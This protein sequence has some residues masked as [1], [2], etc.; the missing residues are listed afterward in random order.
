MGLALANCGRDILF[1]ACSWGADGTP[2]WI[3]ST[4][5]HM[6]RS[7]GDISD[8]WESIKNISIKQAEIVQHAGN[9]CFNDMDMLVVGM[10]G[11]GHVGLTGCTFTEYRLHFSLWALLSS[12]LIIG[13][14]IRNMTDETRKILM[15]EKV[16]SI[17]QD[18]ASR[19][20]FMV[21]SNPNCPIWV[22]M[23]DNGDLAVGLFNFTDNDVRF[24]FSLTDIGIDRTTKMKLEFHNLWEDEVFESR[25]IV[26][27]VIPAHDCL[28][29]RAKVKNI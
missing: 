13:C 8:S 11:V 4:G 5:A 17:N 1:S 3:K 2:E 20:P 29:M 7:T 26:C 18:P 9:G 22:R 16:I 25:D 21:N 23:L 28:L 6:W 12:P 19:Q 27:R 14:D 10:N 24:H 15:N